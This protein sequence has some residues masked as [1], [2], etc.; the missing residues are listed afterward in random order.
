MAHT[1]SR[2]LHDGPDDH[3]YNPFS[4]GRP[5]TAGPAMAALA[6]P[7]LTSTLRTILTHRRLSLEP[8]NP[9]HRPRHRERALPRPGSAAAMAATADW[10][11]VSR[12]VAKAEELAASRSF[13][14][15]VEGQR[16]GSGWKMGR[17]TEVREGCPC[18]LGAAPRVADALCAHIAALRRPHR[19]RRACLPTGSLGAT[20][21][22]RP[23]LPFTST[24][25]SCTHPERG[26]GT[27]LM[28]RSNTRS[29]RAAAP[30]TWLKCRVQ[31]RLVR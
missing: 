17:F 27:V 2:K 26:T 11:T 6:R 9:A 3:P 7:N 14:A 30:C 12:P 19:C 10:A 8:P 16:T 5:S 24:T 1:Y 13:A 22:V 31:V 28:R 18:C 21:A 23:P 29:E 15:T 20:R 25:V 4:V